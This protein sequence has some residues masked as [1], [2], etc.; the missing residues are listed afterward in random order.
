MVKLYIYIRRNHQTLISDNQCHVV[1]FSSVLTIADEL[2]HQKCMSFVYVL[3]KGI[4]GNTRLT[5]EIEIGN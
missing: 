5:V 1:V 4:M 3:L 2:A